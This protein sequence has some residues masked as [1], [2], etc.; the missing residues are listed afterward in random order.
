[1]ASIALKRP[2]RNR[3][4][5]MAARGKHGRKARRAKKLQTHLP[6]CRRH[7]ELQTQT[8]GG[9][10]PWQGAGQ[11]VTRNRLALPVDQNQ[12]GNRIMK[13]REGSR[14]RACGVKI[15]QDG[16]FCDW[17]RQFGHENT[18]RNRLPLPVLGRRPVGQHKPSVSHGRHHGHNNRHAKANPRFAGVRKVSPCLSFC[19]R[20]AFDARILFMLPQTSPLSWGCHRILLLPSIAR[21]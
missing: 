15:Q 5:S 18:R 13:Q 2:E 11:S 16:S 9:A 17:Q 7:I 4:R 10:L 19:L 1:M 12:P 20:A 8:P 6:A 14:V 3:C 21:P